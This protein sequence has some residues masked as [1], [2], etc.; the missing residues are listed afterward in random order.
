MGVRNRSALRAEE[1]LVETLEGY[2]VQCARRLRRA[3]K[4]GSWMM[5][6]PSM[7]NGTGLGAQ[8]YRDVLFLRY[9]LEPPDFP[10]YC[11]R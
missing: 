2:P 3:M 5:V 6:Q 8:E 9:G 1:A 11:D 7:V 4:T 10:K